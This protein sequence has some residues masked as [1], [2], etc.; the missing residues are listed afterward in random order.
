MHFLRY[1]PSRRRGEM[2]GIA[3]ARL[4]SCDLTYLQEIPMAISIRNLNTALGAEIGGIDLSKAIGQGDVD[5]I[6]SVWRERLVV[7]FHGQKLT[8]P[9]LIAFSKRFGEL[10][11]PG[12]NPV[13][14]AVP[15][16]PPSPRFPIGLPSSTTFEMTL[17]S[18]CSVLQLR[19]PFDPKS[20]RVMHRSQIKG[21]ERIA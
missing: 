3:F 17:S 5:A 1:P 7:V 14:R 18:K 11:P 6:D 2:I 8:D 20:R 19:D 13:W 10:D 4:R 21:S 16:G 12:P 15:Q 9:E